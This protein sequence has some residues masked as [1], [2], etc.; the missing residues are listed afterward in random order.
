M[1]DLL[2]GAAESALAQEP[3]FV[4]PEGRTASARSTAESTSAVK[5]RKRIDYHMW[6]T[7]LLLVMIAT[8]ELFSA[9]I[10]ETGTRS[11]S[12]RSSGRRM[13]STMSAIRSPDPRTSAGTSGWLTDPRS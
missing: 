13:P 3:D 6:G 10:Q 2:T 4:I 11:C 5:Q 12:P 1:N 8:L 7:Y 9:S